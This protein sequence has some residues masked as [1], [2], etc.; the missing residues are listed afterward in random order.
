[1]TIWRCT[2]NNFIHVV[3]ITC[4]KSTASRVYGKSFLLKIAAK[5]CPFLFVNTIFFKVSRSLFVSLFK[6]KWKQFSP[7]FSFVIK[8][9]AES[10]AQSPQTI[11]PWGVPE[12]HVTGSTCQL[13][14]NHVA[15]LYS[16]SYNTALTLS[17]LLTSDQVRVATLSLTI[18]FYKCY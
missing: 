2:L 10:P 12:Q 1:M 7:Q 14:G 16:S 5:A 15:A 4:C 3:C 13:H 17:F 18:I 8:T 6:E 9:S 11:Y